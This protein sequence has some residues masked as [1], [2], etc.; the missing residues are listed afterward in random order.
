MLKDI[1]DDQTTLGSQ[2]KI[3]ALKQH[4]AYPKVS[5]YIEQ[6]WF[7]CKQ[8]WMKALQDKNFESGKKIR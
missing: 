1:A 6:W 7:S 2:L 3:K 8:R 4:Q 5:K